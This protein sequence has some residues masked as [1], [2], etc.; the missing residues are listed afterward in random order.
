MCAVGADGELDHYGGGN[1]RKRLTR[2]QGRLT[3]P[4]PAFESVALNYSY[5]E[6]L[7]MYAGGGTFEWV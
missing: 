7:V 3:G 6:S 1:L 5:C 4:Y 2:R